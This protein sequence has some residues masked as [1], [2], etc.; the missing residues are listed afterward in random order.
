MT[1]D[2]EQALPLNLVANVKCGEEVT[3]LSSPDAYTVKVSTADGSTGYVAAMYLKKSQARKRAQDISTLKNGVA[4]WSAGAGGCDH[5]VSSDGSVVESMKVSGITVQV[6]LY[7]T[8]WKFRVQVAVVNDSQAPLSIDPARFILDEVGP[9]GK[10]LFYQDPAELAKNT[11]HQ[12]LWTE[13]AATPPASART[14]LAFTPQALDTDYKVPV[15]S[16]QGTPNYLLAHQDAENEAIRTQGTRT[17]TNYAKQVQALALKATTV[18][19]TD[20]VSGAVWFER[21]K[22]PSQLMLRVPIDSTS[23][24]FPLSFRKSR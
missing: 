20:S 15:R 8:G 3:L 6:S 21:S 11:T 4:H 2:A 14:Q 13:A 22:N 10:P 17:L 7:D 12:V 5:F 23:F 19:P 1:A 9:N 24:E 16:A 18:E